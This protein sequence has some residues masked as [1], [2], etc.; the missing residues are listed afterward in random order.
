MFELRYLPNVV[1]L[2]LESEKCIGCGMCVEVCPHAVFKMEQKKALIADRDAC[3]ECG[4]C[5]R[6]CIANALIVRAGVGC[7]AAVISG[8]TASEPSCGCSVEPAS[9]QCPPAV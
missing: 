5:A 2:K 7:A 6:N 8:Y 9:E 4:A 1:T 3:M